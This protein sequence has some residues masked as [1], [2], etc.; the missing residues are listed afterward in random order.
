MLI[1]S[2][3]IKSQ[4]GVS[5]GKLALEA[6]FNFHSC[7]VNKDLSIRANFIAI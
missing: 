6:D 3:L 2:C 4:F 7:C 5:E 1:L